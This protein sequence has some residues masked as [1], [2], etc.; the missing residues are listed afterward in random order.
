M[1]KNGITLKHQGSFYES[2]AL[3]GMWPVLFLSGTCR[4]LWGLRQTAWKSHLGSWGLA[5]IE[6]LTSSLT[7]FWTNLDFSKWSESAWDQAD[8]SFWSQNCF[9][10]SWGCSSVWFWRPRFQAADWLFVWTG[11]NCRL[12]WVSQILCPGH[13]DLT[14]LCL[15]VTNTVVVS[16]ITKLGPHCSKTAKPFSCWAYFVCNVSLISANLADSQM[17]SLCSILSLVPLKLSRHQQLHLW[18]WRPSL[19]TRREDQFF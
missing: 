6:L 10:W 11:S 16:H 3:C 5:R 8:R 19:E 1:K 4:S 2:T 13:S 7:L 15:C 12:F 18:K 14:Q 17:S 9:D